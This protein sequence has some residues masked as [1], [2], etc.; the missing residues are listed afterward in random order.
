MAYQHYGFW[1][2]MDTIRDKVRL[3]S[4]WETGDAPWKVW[5]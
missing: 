3:E 2:C 4:L 5:R 1:Q